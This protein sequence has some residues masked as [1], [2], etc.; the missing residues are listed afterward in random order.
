MPHM[1]LLYSLV[2]SGGGLKYGVVL[3]HGLD[4]LGDGVRCVAEE[5]PSWRFWGLHIAW[6]TS[7]GC[8]YRTFGTGPHGRERKEGSSGG[9]GDGNSS[10][11]RRVL[12]T[13]R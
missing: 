5:M 10:S 13:S 4:P 2:G 1:D 11:N 3:W 6:L 12:K 9:G 7:L 8:S